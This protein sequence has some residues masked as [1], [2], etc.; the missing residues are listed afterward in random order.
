MYN[1]GNDAIRW[2]IST[3]IKVEI[4]F[5]FASSHYFPDIKYYMISENV[6]P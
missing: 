4:E 3:C 1:I 5:F 2:L 6:E